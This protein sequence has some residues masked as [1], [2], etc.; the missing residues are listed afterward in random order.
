M[1]RWRL[2]TRMSPVVFLMAVIS[3]VVVKSDRIHQEHGDI[4][5]VDSVPA[6]CS[7]A[8]KEVSINGTATDLF[9]KKHPELRVVGR[10]CLNETEH[11]TLVLG[12]DLH[13]CNL[14]EGS[15]RSAVVDLNRLMYLSLEANPIQNV[16]EADLTKN[17]DIMYLCLPPDIPCPGGQDAWRSEDLINNVR[18]CREELNPCKYRNVSCPENSHCVQLGFSLTECLCNEGFHGYKCMNEGTFP[19]MAFI[20]GV[21]IPTVLIS[22]FLWVTQRRYVVRV[23][24]QK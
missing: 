19:T 9:C 10:C 22:I 1:N 4:E 15:L 21:S 16:T 14:T 5:N 13:D 2:G 6:V 24:K 11:A 7:R 20:A 8:C 3:L 12:L 23:T 18:I 17:T